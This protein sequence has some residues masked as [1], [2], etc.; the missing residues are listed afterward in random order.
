MTKSGQRVKLGVIEHGFLKRMALAD[1]PG[2]CPDLLWSRQDSGLDGR[3][4][5]GIKN[6][7]KGMAEDETAENKSPSVEHK[8]DEVK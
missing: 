4:R 1:R 2:R 7:K 3:C 8:A 5:Q 6:F